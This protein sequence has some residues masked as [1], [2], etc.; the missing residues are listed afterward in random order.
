[1]VCYVE[2]ADASPD[3]DA[4][5]VFLFPSHED[6]RWWNFE[7]FVQNTRQR[8]RRWVLWAI[9]TLNLLL[10]TVDCRYTVT[11]TMST[12]PLQMRRHRNLFWGCSVFIGAWT[13]YGGPDYLSLNLLNLLTFIER[14]CDYS[15]AILASTIK[16]ETVNNK[17]K[18]PPGKTSKSDCPLT[19]P[20]WNSSSLFHIRLS[21]HTMV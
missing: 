16:D 17:G 12:T 6:N 18:R 1:M 9:L 5:Q 2:A 4:V 10:S 15:V 19:L 3:Y 20:G 14:F 21:N 8:W 13:S 7:L 11:S